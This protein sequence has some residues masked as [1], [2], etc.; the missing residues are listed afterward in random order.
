MT[1]RYSTLLDQGIGRLSMGRRGGLFSTGSSTVRENRLAETHRCR[2]E[3]RAAKTGCAV[4]KKG[5]CAQN[6]L[7]ESVCLWSETRLAYSLHVSAVCREWI[8]Q[9]HCRWFFFRQSPFAAPYTRTNHYPIHYRKRG[10]RTR[11]ARERE[12]GRVKPVSNPI[13]PHLCTRIQCQ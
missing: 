11:S 13:D 3:R 7:P 5:L 9:E 1:T 8:R 4:W 6:V 12:R 2:F 10:N